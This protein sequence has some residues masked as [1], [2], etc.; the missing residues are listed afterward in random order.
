MR[1][2]VYHVIAI[3]MIL[4]GTSS[5]ITAQTGEIDDCADGIKLTTPIPF[6]GDCI[7]K[8][9]SSDTQN[10]TNIINAFPRLM[11]G[12]TRILMTIILVGAFIGILVGWLM[13][14]SH[15][16]TGKQ[17]EWKDLL[18]KIV[19]ALAL[20]GIMGAILNAINPNFFKTDSSIIRTL[21]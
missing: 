3:I 20:V 6:I 5:T 14:A 1:I 7:L 11:W 17:S 10:R 16:F 4:L 9:S 8:T 12:L 2:R 19:A 18:I 21:T 15:G 13:I